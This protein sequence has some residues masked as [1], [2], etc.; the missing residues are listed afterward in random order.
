MVRRLPVGPHRFLYLFFAWYALSVIWS[1]APGYSAVYLCYIAVGLAVSLITIFVTPDEMSMRRVMQRL[2]I[3]VALDVMFS[4][5][6]AFTSFRLPVS[7]YSRFV[8]YFGR[9]ATINASLEDRVVQNFLSSPTGFQWNP[10]DLAATLIIFLPFCLFH[11]SM[12]LR[13]IGGL[14]MATVIF[15]TG[16]RAS[17]IGLA[18]VVLVWAIAFSAKRA[19]I[20]LVFIV[21]AAL[22]LP[23]AL[24]W[25]AASDDP[26]LVQF[27]TMSEALREYVSGRSTSGDSIGLRQ[28]LIRNGLIAL[29]DSGGVGVGGGGSRAVQESAGGAAAAIGSMHN[30]WIEVLV[31]AGVVMGVAFAA[32]YLLLIFRC[33]SVAITTRRPVLRFVASSLT[34]SLVGFTVAMLSSS[35]VIY[36]LPMWLMFGLSSSVIVLDR[37]ARSGNRMHSRAV[38]SSA[39]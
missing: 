26:R 17:Y 7:P 8:E 22:I 37:S 25:M 13:V 1:V 18:L 12:T 11:R 36:S 3:I 6:E 14:S 23:A 10:N 4:V 5:F 29:R 28:Q 38:G 34:C 24:T 20:C 15:F 19:L 9:E 31:D 16:S 32:W 27:G 39:V 2:G 21:M 33:Y 30:F 35:S